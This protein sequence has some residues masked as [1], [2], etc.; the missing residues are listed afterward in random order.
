[1]LL[2]WFLE[3]M[4]SVSVVQGVVGDRG[5]NMFTWPFPH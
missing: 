5:R 2:S 1:M 4:V 3:D